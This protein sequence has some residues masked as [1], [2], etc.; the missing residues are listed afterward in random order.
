MK[1]NVFSIVTAYVNDCKYIQ[2]S[3][4]FEASTLNCTKNLSQ[5]RVRTAAS[6]RTSVL[7]QAQIMYVVER[8]SRVKV[9]H[10]TR[11]TIH[12]N[13]SCTCISTRVLYVHIS[14]Y[15][16]VCKAVSHNSP[17]PSLNAHFFIS[18]HFCCFS[19]TIALI[20]RGN[21]FPKPRDFPQLTIYDSFHFI[22][23]NT[24]LL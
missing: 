19:G 13:I 17:S 12:T 16:C 8:A 4:W 9:L 21:L 3:M 11:I 14:H 1:R 20:L 15:T 6:E 24:N 23:K 22:Y 10:D 7:I 5:G 18:I 2:L